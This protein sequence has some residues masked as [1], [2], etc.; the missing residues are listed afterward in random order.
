MLESVDRSVSKTDE[1][2]A[3]E[4]SSPSLGTD[5]LPTLFSLG[6]IT[7]KTLNVFLVLAFLVSGFVFW[8]RGRADHYREDQLFDGFVIGGIVGLIFARMAFCLFQPGN[9]TNVGQCI[10][11]LTKPGWMGGVGLSIAGL[12]LIRFSRKQKWDPLAILDM[13]VI[14][15][16]AGV[17]VMNMGMLVAGAGWGIW[18]TWQVPLISAGMFLALF[19]FLGW[20]EQ[21]YRLF[22]W[23]KHGRSVAQTGF[24]TAVAL[25]VGSLIFLLALVLQMG[26]VSST[27]MIVNVAIYLCWFGTGIILLLIRSGIIGRVLK[28][29]PRHG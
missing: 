5:M 16:S 10:D 13:W 11:M 18:L 9:L 26:V 21:H 20:T 8:K 14:A 17:A 4:G 12:A 2:Q 19:F 29:S 22:S 6:P 28:K 23:Y 27:N 24:V 1:P 3:R 7:I 25:M 15:V